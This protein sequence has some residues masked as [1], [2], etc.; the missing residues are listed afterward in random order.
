[1]KNYT[2]MRREEIKYPK[3]YKFIHFKN[4]EAY[5]SYSYSK[6]ALIL[7][8]KDRVILCTVPRESVEKSKSWELLK[9]L[10][11]ERN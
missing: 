5:I 7:L 10:K 3:C 8:G 1:M 6:N 4:V 11:N 2:K 9:I